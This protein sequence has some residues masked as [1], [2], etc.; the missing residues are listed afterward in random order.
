[1]ILAEILKVLPSFQEFTH[2]EVVVRF[3]ILGYTKDGDTPVFNVDIGT[4]D[5][6]T[7]IFDIKNYGGVFNR[8]SGWV[9]M[10]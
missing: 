1:M 8:Q 3:Q 9:E 10:T 5:E 4:D 2:V 6:K 7:T